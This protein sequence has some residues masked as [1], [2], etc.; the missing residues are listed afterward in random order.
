MSESI[1][2]RDDCVSASFDSLSSRH[3]LRDKLAHLCEF[4]FFPAVSECVYV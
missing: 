3:A 1:C 2:V 4:F